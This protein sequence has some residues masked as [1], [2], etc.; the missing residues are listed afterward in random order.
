MTYRNEKGYLTYAGLAVERAL[1]AVGAHTGQPD[2]EAI[3]AVAD[4]TIRGK[5]EDSDLT[6]AARFESS[7]GEL[8][9]DLL[10]A[11]DAAS[12]SF[13]AALTH[14]KKKHEHEKTLDAAK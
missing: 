3:A 6:S 9:A 13:E 12:V 7:L 2:Q 4:L 10:H 14:A 11:A 8:L 1:A 5:Q